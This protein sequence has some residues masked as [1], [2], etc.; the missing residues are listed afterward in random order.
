ML[1]DDDIRAMVRL[2]GEVGGSEAALN[3]KRVQLLEGIQQLID[4]DM[5]TWSLMGELDPA[6]PPV[7]TIFLHGGFEDDQLA[8]HLSLQEHPDLQWLTAPLMTKLATATGQVTRTRQQLVSEEVLLS[9]KIYPLFLEADLGATMLSG[10]PT[11][12]GQMSMICL[13]RRVDKPLFSE[14]DARIAHILLSEV[15]W[16]HDSAWPNHPRSGIMNL[17]RRQ[18]SVLPLLLQ[19]LSRKEIAD[20]LDFSEHTLNDHTKDI[21]KA[22]DVHSQKELMRV[23]HE[24]DGGDA[25]QGQAVA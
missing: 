5:W 6:S 12:Q 24:G 18:R 22:F 10:R 21:Y 15:P 1:E 4:A 3:N 20:L 14:R 2:L 17:T 7:H 16:L 13:F 23:F 8:K 11:S 9:S 19:G 25:S